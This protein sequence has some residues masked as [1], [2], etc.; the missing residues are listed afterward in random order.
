VIPAAASAPAPAA[1]SGVAVPERR[2]GPAVVPALRRPLS[3]RVPRFRLAW[4]PW[5]LAAALIAVALWVPILMVARG[6]LEPAGET[7]AHLART[8]LPGYAATSIVLAAAAGALALVVGAGTAWLVAACAFPGRRFFEWALV[9]PLSVPA[10][11]AAY[12]YAG[13]LDVAGPVQR[14]IRTL[15]PSLADRFLHVEVAGLGVAILIFAGV[16]YPY[17]YVAARASFLRQSRTALEAS[18][19]LG[20][21]AASTF[22]R[23]A[24]PLARP[25][26][27]AG[28]SLVVLEVLNDYGAVKY[29]GVSTFTTGIFR[30]W[31]GLGD[32]DAAIRLAAFLL[33]VVFAVLTLER[34]QRGRRSVAPSAEMERPLEPYRLR[35]WAAAAAFTAC[36]VPVLFGFLIPVAQLVYWA[37]RT[38][39]RV[40]DAEF[41]AM[42]ARSFALALGAAAL[43]VALAVV[44]AYAA[45]LGRSALVRGIARVAVLGYA[46]P[47]AVIAVGVLVPLGALDRALGSI[48]QAITGASPGLVIGGTVLALIYAYSVRY[49]AVAYLPV[50]AGFERECRGLDEASRCLGVPPLATLRRVGLPL[51]RGVLAGALILVFVDVL[52]ELPLTLVLRPFDFDTLATRAY[53]LA[54]DEQ[55]AES[56]NAA[57]VLIAVSVPAIIGVNRLLGRARP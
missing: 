37:A 51:M 9:L 10:Y 15:F 20:R 54:S 23:V 57:L 8:V 42:L 17:V 44:I 43:V 24:L 13:M 55:V 56:A 12:T 31:F 35:G 53:Q 50:E 49:L 16:L 6:V 41:V 46:V 7:W 25:A 1:P 48:V 3:I 26:L 33:L 39:P 5:T 38:A 19:V 28:A 32:L 40:V 11:V 2:P 29:L 22:F 30:A 21:S 18:R 47:G 36:A 52:K 14:V 45:R 27:V 4:N 34:L